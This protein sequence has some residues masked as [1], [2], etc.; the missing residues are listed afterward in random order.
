MKNKIKPGLD[1]KSLYPNMS[2][3]KYLNFIQKHNE[4]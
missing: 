2:I 4:K 3:N 1:I